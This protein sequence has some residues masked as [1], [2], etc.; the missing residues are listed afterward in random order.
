MEAEKSRLRRNVAFVQSTMGPDQFERAGE[1]VA[2]HVSKTRE[3]EAADIVALYAATEGEVGTRGV[4]DSARALEKCCVF[5]RCLEGNQLEFATVENWHELEPGRFGILEPPAGA[6]RV[7]LAEIDLILVPGLAFDRIGGRLGR[8]AGYYD[9][10]LTE[11]GAASP[12]LM[13]VAHSVQLFES[14]PMDEHDRPMHAVALETGII[15]VDRP[16]KSV[17]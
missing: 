6:R 4:F 13:G 15:W 5:P 9:R 7:S 12:I 8:G 16:A 17:E 3:F 1:L 10:A 14:V 2:E 11:V